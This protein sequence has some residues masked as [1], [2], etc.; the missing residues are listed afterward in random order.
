MIIT[1]IIKRIYLHSPKEN[2]SYL[3]E[4]LFKFRRKKPNNQ[5]HI[6]S[7]DDKLRSQLEKAM[8]KYTT[9]N[10]VG[11]SEKEFKEYLLSLIGKCDAEIEGFKGDEK[12]RDLSIKFVWGHNH[13]FGSFKLRGQMGDRYI[14]LFENY[15]QHFGIKMEEFNNKDVLDVGCWT[16]E[17]SLLLT[18]FGAKVTAI[19]EVKKYAKATDWLARK[20]GIND[21]LFVEAK[22]LYECDNNSY[23]DKFDYVHFSGVI[24]HLTDPV[25]G[26]RVLFNA[27]RPGGIML[28][29]SAGL[30]SDELICKYEGCSFYHDGTKKQLNRGGWNWFIPSKATLKLMIENV[31]FRNVE[32]K[33]L[34]G[35][36]YG[37]GKKI[38]HE[39]ITRAGLS[40]PDIR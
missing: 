5:G 14:K 23:Y 40:K 36:L 29:E 31:G 4:K 12:Q 13:D 28:I 18:A 17:T 33:W 27:L 32:V 19:E 3:L 9:E 35:R 2:I 34:S 22:S 16:G 7:K 24:Y 37:I 25:V 15:C 10:L 6:E 11:I 1:K 21:T 30:D 39:E 26:L 20:F 38:Q 8:K